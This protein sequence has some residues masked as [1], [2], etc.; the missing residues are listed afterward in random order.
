MK[1]F[2]DNCRIAAEY[3]KDS[4]NTNIEIWGDAIDLLKMLTTVTNQIA[5][6]LGVSGSLVAA[7][8]GVTADAMRRT[9]GEKIITDL[10]AIQRAKDK[11]DGD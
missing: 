5:E 2:H 11:R 8:I 4:G 10:V 7:S 6:S 9:E 3:D 1:V